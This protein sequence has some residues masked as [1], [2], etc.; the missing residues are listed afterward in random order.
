MTKPIVKLDDLEDELLT[1]FRKA[2]KAARKSKGK[3]SRVLYVKISCDHIGK[4]SKLEDIAIQ[5]LV[6]N[7]GSGSSMWFKK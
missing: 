2:R 7:E 1:A 4:N 3:S 6:P 5:S